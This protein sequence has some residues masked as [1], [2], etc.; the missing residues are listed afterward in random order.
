M[1]C[2]TVA[3][4]LLY[5]QN[6]LGCHNINFVS[7]SHFVPQILKTLLLAV[8]MGLKIPLVYNTSGYD[9]LETIKTLDGI[10][11]IYLPDLRYGSDKI[12]KFYSQVPN[13]VEHARS[14]IKEMYRQAG[15]LL[16]D[17]NAIAQRGL[18]V[19]HLILPGGLAGSEESLTW[20][21]KEVS[22]ELNV[23]LMAQYYPAHHAARF[24][25]LS[26]GISEAE[27]FEV[28]DLLDKLNM[29]NGWIQEMSASDN[30]QPDFEQGG[31]PFNHP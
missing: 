4:K 24:P 11:D 9:S 26:C 13:Y 5:L 16:L 31:H 19:R 1:E 10:I 27:Y 28:I 7:P 8:P 3:E 22:P 12:A 29:D 17:E 25:A 21:A 23:S 30:Y 20:L 2:Q 18:I 6:E 15:N 14:V